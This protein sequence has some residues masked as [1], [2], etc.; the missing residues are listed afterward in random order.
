MK[1]IISGK[2]IFFLNQTLTLY[3]LMNSYLWFGCNK[4]GMVHRLYRGI[5]DYNFQIKFIDCFV[6]ANSV[7]PD[8]MLHFIWVFTVCQST[9][10]VVTRIPIKGLNA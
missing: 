10:L 1:G 5:T 9:H 3:A 6:L 7:D 8:E 4:L 2:K